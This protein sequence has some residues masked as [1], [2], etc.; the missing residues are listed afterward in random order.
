ME[1]PV[2]IHKESKSDY[3]VTVPDLPGCFSAGT[4]INA[5]LKQTKEAIEC[6]I[7]GLLLDGE[8]IPP[9]KPIEE[10]INNPE[11]KDAIV[12]MVS[13]DLSHIGGKSERVNITLPENLL[14][15]IDRYTKAHGLNRSSFL[16]DAAMRSMS[17]QQ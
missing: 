16:A 4:N 10:H 11:F 8:E 13:F 15:Q 9:L 6:H 3:G 12:A 1:Y 7:E 17:S 14:R 2:F 5:A